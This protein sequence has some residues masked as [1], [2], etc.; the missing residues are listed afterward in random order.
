M[1]SHVLA[2]PRSYGEGAEL[3]FRG[4]FDFVIRHPSFSRLSTMAVGSPDDYFGRKVEQVFTPLFERAIRFIEGG[5][6]AGV[7]RPIDARSF[8]MAMY[9]MTI[10]GF[11]DAHF[12]GLLTG[13]DPSAEEAARRRLDCLVD[14][15]LTTLGVHAA[16]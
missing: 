10:T 11:S 8:L 4:F 2:T 6:E 3:I 16:S 9:G 12:L 1:I 15:L 5:I 7:F 14:I 13:E